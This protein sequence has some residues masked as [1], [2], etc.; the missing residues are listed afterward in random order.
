MGGDP[1][2]VD[3][4]R[5]LDQGPDGEVVMINL[6]RFAEGDGQQVEKYVYAIEPF[7]AKVGAVIVH[8]GTE[9]G[10][11]GGEEPWDA[12][13]IAKYPSRDAISQ[14]EKDPGYAWIA[15]MRTRSQRSTTLQPT[16]LK[17]G[18]WVKAG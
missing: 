12:I 3:L 6:L 10:V 2:V 17:T 16:P 5:I 18:G 11:L 7:L 8:Y 4:K 15:N 9:T 1:R 14:L 13:V